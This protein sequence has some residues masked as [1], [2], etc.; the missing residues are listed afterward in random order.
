MNSQRWAQALRKEKQK[1]EDRL[2]R[3]RQQMS[4]DLSSQVHELSRYDNDPADLGTETFERTRDRRFLIRAEQQLR[5]I[6]EAEGRLARGTYGSC[7]RCGESISEERL[8]AVPQAR[9][10]Q[11]C[12]RSDQDGSGEG[13]LDE[14][15]NPLAGPRDGWPEEEPGTRPPLLP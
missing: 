15:Y 9:L 7:Q 6:E 1:L 5:E 12:A 14:E 4:T 8:E 13:R 2:E 11:G 3:L 10:C